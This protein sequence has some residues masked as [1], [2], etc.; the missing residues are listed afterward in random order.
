MANDNISNLTEAE[1]VIFYDML[2]RDLGDPQSW[3]NNKIPTFLINTDEITE[4]LI[5]L[6]ENC[7]KIKLETIEL[8][9][10]FNKIK[11]KKKYLDF[12]KNQIKQ[13]AKKKK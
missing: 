4:G 11:D 10:P 8:D 13:V 3:E 9:I 7:L 2:V 1:Q 5:F 12:L 6:E